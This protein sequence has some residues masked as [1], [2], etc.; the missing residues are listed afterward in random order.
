M[1]K[2]DRIINLCC[3]EKCSEV[4][5]QSVKVRLRDIIVEDRARRRFIVG[6]IEYNQCR[7]IIVTRDSEKRNYTEGL[8][9]SKL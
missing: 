8:S 7:M 1:W 3:R 5:Q 4:F 2:I 6:G 9:I